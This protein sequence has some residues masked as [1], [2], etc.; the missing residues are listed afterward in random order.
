MKSKYWAV[1]IGLILL[2][3][4]GASLFLMGEK[5]PAAMAEI[6]SDGTLIRTVSLTDNQE[7]TVPFPG[8]FNTVTVKDGKIAVTGADCP[9]G[10]CMERGFCSSGTP[11]VCL[12]H[13]LVIEFVGEQEIDGLIG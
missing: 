1:L 13:K 6:R 5:A 10:Y 4:I 3:C 9:D 7:F 12:P 11:I 8:G 2:L